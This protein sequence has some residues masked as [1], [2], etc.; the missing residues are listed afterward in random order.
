MNTPIPQS[1]ML[2]NPHDRELSR[3]R[4]PVVVQ[5][6]G[7]WLFLLGVLVASLF[8]FTDHWRRAT[9]TLGASMIFLAILRLSCDSHIMGLLAVR[10]R[11][12]DAFYCTVM[13]ALMSFLA[14]SVDSLG[15]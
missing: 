14:L 5:R 2:A 8:A 9:F 1:E 11:R 10:S 6:I 15:S 3:S 12:F 4:L 7:V 13:G